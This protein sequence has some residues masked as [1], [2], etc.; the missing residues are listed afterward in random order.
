MSQVV[1]EEK[2]LSDFMY[3]ITTAYERTCHLANG[4]TLQIHL[5]VTQDLDV[6]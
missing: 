1:N 4:N 3:A 5:Q 2:C 6:P